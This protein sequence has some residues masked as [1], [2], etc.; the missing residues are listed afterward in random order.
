MTVMKDILYG[1]VITIAL[2]GFAY[3]MDKRV[4]ERIQAAIDESN[5]QNIEQRIQFYIIKNETAGLTGE[6][7]I[8]M[9]IL[10]RQLKELRAK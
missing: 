9:Q 5:A 7:R 8:N 2:T 4:D 3:A 10:E 1:V 6:D